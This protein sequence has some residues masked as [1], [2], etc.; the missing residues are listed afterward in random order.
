MDSYSGVPNKKKISRNKWR[1]DV[2]KCNGGREKMI[3]SNKQGDSIN[4]VVG[5]LL[6]ANL[7][8]KASKK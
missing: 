1:R 6:K 8:D 7:Y 4:G 2:R 3:I 5:K